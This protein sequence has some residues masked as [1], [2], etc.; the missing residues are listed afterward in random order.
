MKCNKII[1]RFYYV[2][3]VN[4]LHFKVPKIPVHHHVKRSHCASMCTCASVALYVCVLNEV[5]KQ[6]YGQQHSIIKCFNKRTR[7]QQQQQL[8]WA[9]TKSG[10]HAMRRRSTKRRQRLK[11]VYACMCVCVCLSPLH[12]KKYWCIA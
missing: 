10:C 8:A 12:T 5:H 6:I 3:R 4:H 7:L 11:Y 1:F 2:S 9:C